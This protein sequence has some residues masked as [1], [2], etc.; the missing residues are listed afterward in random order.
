MFTDD[1][2]SPTRRR[3]DLSH[4]TIDRFRVPGCRPGT[5][6]SEV[7]RLNLFFDKV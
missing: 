7:P 6:A 2:K 5:T 1:H 3:I 4:N